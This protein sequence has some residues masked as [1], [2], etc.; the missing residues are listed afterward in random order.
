MLKINV[1][2]FNEVQEHAREALLETAQAVFDVSQQ[3]CPVDTGALR[4]SG[5][6]EPNGPDQVI[7]AYGDDEKVTY[8][9]Y[10]EFGTVNMAAQPFLTPA[11]VTAPETFAD[12]MQRKR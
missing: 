4:A 11:A 8:A 3:L 1:E 9:K 2:A 10:Q 7:I 5:R 6:V 12:I